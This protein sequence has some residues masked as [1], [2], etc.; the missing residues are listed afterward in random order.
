MTD[1]KTVW[2]CLSESPE[3][4]LSF[5]SAMLALQLADYAAPVAATLFDATDRSNARGRFIDVGGGSGHVCRYLAPRFPE[6]SYEVQ[7][8]DPRQWEVALAEIKAEAP[9]LEGR[10]E[11]KQQSFFEPLTPEPV[12]EG[13]KKPVV[14]FMSQ[15][16]H[17]WHDEDAKKIIGNILPCLLADKENRSILLADILLWDFGEVD[18]I[19]ER[20]ARRYDMT[21]LTYNGA[22]ERSRAEWRELFKSVDPK[23]EMVEVRRHQTSGSSMAVLEFKLVE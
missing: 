3:Q 18:P 22:K 20:D 15:I 4:A 14:Y 2:Q 17:D 10:I 19:E 1:G 23:F 6:W 9:E 7:D 16:L 21:M 5:S 11:F 8:I 12:S 13:E